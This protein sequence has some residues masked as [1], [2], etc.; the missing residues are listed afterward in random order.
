MNA[1]STTSSDQTYTSNVNLVSAFFKNVVSEGEK[2][3]LFHKKKGKWTGATWNEIADSIKRLSGA[4]VAAGVQ[5]RDRVLIC[6]E[7]RPEWAIADLAIMAIGAIVVPAYTTNTEDDH[8]Y[9]MEHSGAVAII[10]SG[11]I[12][13]NRVALAASRVPNIRLLIT[14]DNDTTLPELAAATTYTWQSL[15]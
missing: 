1:D 13:G 3:L 8:V 4:L 2:P 11:G 10:T 5:P 14:M 9:I 12:L 6:A 15:L 7:N